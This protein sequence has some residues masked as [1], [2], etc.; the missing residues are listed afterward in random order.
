MYLRSI[1]LTSLAIFSNYYT[2]SQSFTLSKE[3]SIGLR[4]GEISWGDINNDG[5]LDFVQTGNTIDSKA[6]TRLF[7]NTSS[8]FVEVQTDLPKIF[9]GRSDWGDYDNDG[10]LDLL[11]AGSAGQLITRIYKNVNGVLQWDNTIQLHGI[12]RGSVEWGDY[13][14][15]GDLDILL[16]G[17]DTNSNSVTKIYRNNTGVFSEISSTGI[18]GVSFGQA[19]WVD[20][21]S[22]GDL[23]VMICGV[24]G[25]APNT[26]PRVT[27]LYIN[28]GTAFTHVFQDSFEALNY[29]SMDF[30]DYDND[31]DLDILISGFTNSFTA[32]TAIYQNNGTSFDIVYDGTLPK[33]LEGKVLWADTDNDG[34]LDIYIAGNIITNNEKIAQLYTNTGSGF[35]LEYSFTE[36]GQGTAAFA[37]FDSD[38][39]LDIFISGQ[40]NNSDLFSGLYRNENV[41]QTLASNAN[42]PP[43]A[44]LN[45][46]SEV[47][48]KKL[49]LSWDKSTDNESLKASLTYNVYLRNETDTIVQPLSIATGKRKVFKQGN[50]GSL[51]SYSLI[52]LK[53]GDYL[54]SVQAIDNSFS[55]SSFSQEENVHINFPPKIT[56]VTTQFTTEGET[57][58]LITVNDFTIEDPDLTTT[59]F[60]L[61]VYGGNNYSVANNIITPNKN[62]AGILFIPVSVSDGLD[63]S[64]KFTIEVEVIIIIGVTE[65]LLEDKFSVYPNPVR[66]Q[67][68]IK[69]N[70]AN[71]LLQVRIYTA[72]GSWI[73]PSIDKNIDGIN[74]IDLSTL[75]SGLYVLWLKSNDSITS[76]K[77]VKE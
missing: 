22:D 50:T 39:D 61:T 52:N 14:A 4:N 56:G 9:E 43:L 13:D 65:S 76:T 28:T 15:D 12:D 33:V 36:V 16:S 72:N 3:F 45:L 20:F 21:D 68:T 54:W 17:Q 73:N 10:D 19:S 6:T 63:E 42:T 66:D 59:E 67:L 49:R 48:N 64:A 55:G 60:T 40:K 31:G 38:G 18:T 34:D 77:I 74:L 5:K 69:T 35:Q 75:K 51:N 62:F 25:T 41:N 32:F 30:G 44:P 37:D 2:Y 71:E 53:P 29:S 1:L 46:K 26:G 58:L 70:S 23:D 7:I 8:G 27:E 11:I 47:V 24:T 57:P